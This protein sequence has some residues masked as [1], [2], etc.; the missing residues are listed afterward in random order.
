VELVFNG[1]RYHAGLLSIRVHAIAQL[2]TMGRQCLENV[3]HEQS[4][5]CRLRDG[6]HGLHVSWGLGSKIHVWGEPVRTPAVA[7]GCDPF[8]HNGHNYD[9]PVRTLQGYYAS[10][11]ESRCRDNSGGPMYCRLPAGHCAQG[12]HVDSAPPVPETNWGALYGFWG[13]PLGSS[14]R[15]E[16]RSGE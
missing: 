10:S 9:I 14:A 5:I 15:A 2:A 12:I 13:T 1:L 8:F 4:W 7:E 11:Y 16:E 6:H 3:P